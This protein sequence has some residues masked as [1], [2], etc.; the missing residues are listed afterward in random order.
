VKK[1]LL[2]G[3]CHHRLCLAGELLSLCLVAAFGRGCRCLEGCTNRC[4]SRT[5]AVATLETLTMTLNCRLVICHNF[6]IVGGRKQTPRKLPS[7]VLVLEGK[8]RLTTPLWP[9]FV[10]DSDLY[11]PHHRLHAA[12]T[13]F[14]GRPVEQRAYL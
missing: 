2:G 8:N 5:V 3:L 9:L 14:Q 1:T 6:T 4:L 11:L 10:P 13:P 7:W 12:L